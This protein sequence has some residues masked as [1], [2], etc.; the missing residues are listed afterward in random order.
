MNMFQSLIAKKIFTTSALVLLGGITLSS[1]VVGVT[2]VIGMN[3]TEKN[4]V[5]P[6]LKDTTDLEIEA[7]DSLSKSS[8]TNSST[9]TT[10]STQTDSTTQKTGSTTGKTTFTN[11]N[12]TPTSKPLAQLN[13]NTTAAQN[14]STNTNACIVTLFGN[15]YDVTS[16]R[17]THSGGDVFVCN[18]DMTTTYQNQH[19]TNLSRMQP[20]LVTG[21]TTNTNTGQ[22]V[23]G[24]SSY[25]QDDDIDE[26]DDEHE[27]EPEE[28]QEDKS[29]DHEENE[30]EK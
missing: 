17:Q 28:E 14:T 16:L 3:Q 12:P 22:S 29:E 26:M 19:G 30:T 24:S 4:E 13:Q 10:S 6:E 27:D 2:K 9:T 18:S 23:S 25:R 20:Y 15:Q 21:S 8:K 11:N 7:E 5:V 1:S